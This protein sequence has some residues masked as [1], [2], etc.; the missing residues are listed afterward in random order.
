MSDG[1]RGGDD[2]AGL[3]RKLIGL[4]VAGLIVA[5]MVFAWLLPRQP[6]NPVEQR[7]EA[8]SSQYHPGGS[9]CDPARL[10]SLTGRE[11]ASESDRCQ[12]AAARHQQEQNDLFQQRRMAD[13]AE[14]MNSLTFKQSQAL[15]VQSAIVFLAF[16]AALAAAWYAK[17]AADEAKR[18]ADEAAAATDQ[19]IRTNDLTLAGQRPWISIAITPKHVR[20]EG[21]CIFVQC[22][23]HFTNLG[24]MVAERF[25][26]RATALR[27]TGSGN[28]L[29]ALV[30]KW[31]KWNESPPLGDSAVMPGETL[32]VSDRFVFEESD[33]LWEIGFTI[34]HIMVAAFYQNRSAKSGVARTRRIF[35][36]SSD[37]TMTGVFGIPQGNG[38]YPEESLIHRSAYGGLAD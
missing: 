35:Q 16:F 12:A 11:A 4:S 27:S 18:G 13:A 29:V 36:V 37:T 33:L 26:Y 9:Q 23:L 14:A 22:D 38:N 7:I 20:N 17:R 34:P 10:R 19:M 32:I 6:D 3:N 30:D 2:K 25:D 31:N 1:D 24:K 28:P 15:A 8:Q 21:G 5:A